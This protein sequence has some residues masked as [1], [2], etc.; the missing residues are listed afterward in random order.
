[1]M[2]TTWNFDVFVFK[3]SGWARCQPLI[4]WGGVIAK[5]NL[6]GRNIYILSK[7]HMSR[8]Y[9]PLERSVLMYGA[10]YLLLKS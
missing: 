3:C 5:V 4:Y 7:F 9:V 10:V 2:Q 6:P 8:L 1:M